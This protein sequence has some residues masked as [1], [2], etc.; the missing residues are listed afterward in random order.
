MLRDDWAAGIA[1]V[2]DH[3]QQLHF[4]HRSGI[5]RPSKMSVLAKMKRAVT[6]IRAKRSDERD[7]HPERPLIR[8]QN[9][10]L[11]APGVPPSPPLP[12]PWTMATPVSR[13]ATPRIL[14]GEADALVDPLWFGYRSSKQ[15]SSDE[16]SRP[17]TSIPVTSTRGKTV[18]TN[19]R[20]PANSN[21]T[22]TI[23]PTRTTLI[24]HP[25]SS[26]KASETPS[27][28]PQP[29]SLVQPPFPRIPHRRMH[30]LFR[31]GAGGEGHCD[32]FRLHDPPR[33]LLAVK[34]LKCTFRPL[35]LIRTANHP[36][37]KPFEAYI[38][39]DLLPPHTNIIRFHDYTSNALTTKFY[40]EYC[41][42]GDLQDVL[43]S[44]FKRDVKVPEPFLWHTFLQLARALHHLHTAARDPR[45]GAPVTILHRDIKPVN[46]LLR[47]SSSPNRYPDVVLADF[48][49]SSTHPPPSSASVRYS[50]VGSIT[51]QGPEVPLQNAAGDVWALGA[52]V[53]ALAHGF[54]PM[55]LQPQRVR[56]EDWAWD[57]LSRVVED[58]R[59]RGYSGGLY[60]CLKGCLRLQWRGRWD[61]G[62]VV[63]KVEEEMGG[64]MEGVDGGEGGLEEW[65]FGGG[66]KEKEG[67]V[68]AWEMGRV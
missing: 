26:R 29:H 28:S 67:D 40:T 57:P 44:H 65:A 18:G 58:V 6:F 45:S 48:G 64:R 15:S 9:P 10:R 50:C 55:A 63:G 13:E 68:Q 8:H 54:P 46:V 31:L 3:T 62:E 39:Q 5:P 11:N 41:P 52:T 59:G 21:T 51:Y 56:Y 47:P 30:F 35:S 42:L 4:R 22:S 66:G 12:P 16:S 23:V 36:K 1:V 33:T 53:H 7:D 24:P 60:R 32:L 2:H 27:S 17:D 61:A 37:G 43:D 25:H 20:S 34:T 49:C 14:P 38:L 19:V